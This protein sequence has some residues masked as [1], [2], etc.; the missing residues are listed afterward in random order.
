MRSLQPISSRHFTTRKTRVFRA[1]KTAFVGIEFFKSRFFRKNRFP[2]IDPCPN[3]YCLKCS[4]P[5]KYWHLDSRSH[6]KT[7]FNLGLDKDYKSFLLIQY[8]DICIFKKLFFTCLK[9][10]ANS[11]VLTGYSSIAKF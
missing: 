5:T 3:T 9:S 7:R 4:F 10:E 6:Y 11:Q 2:P 8:K 1:R